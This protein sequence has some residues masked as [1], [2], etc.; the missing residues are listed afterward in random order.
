[1]QLAPRLQAISGERPARSRT[2]L[3]IRSSCAVP[4]S[5]PADEVLKDP[6]FVESI[7]REL[8]YRSTAAQFDYKNLIAD[9][10]AR[11]GCKRQQAAG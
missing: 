8:H 10:K 3:A 6:E 11:S 7:N 4:H 5:L 9:Y 1:M 2:Q